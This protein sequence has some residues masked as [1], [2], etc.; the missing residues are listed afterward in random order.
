[1]TGG[2]HCPDCDQAHNDWDEA[3]TYAVDD[4]Y[5]AGIIERWECEHCGNILEGGRV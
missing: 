2:M 3:G 5:H 4:G 1:M